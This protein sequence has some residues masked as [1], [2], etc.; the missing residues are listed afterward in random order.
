MLQSKHRESKKHWAGCS[1][2]SGIAG[3]E[4]VK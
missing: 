3:S 4:H 2:A 1:A